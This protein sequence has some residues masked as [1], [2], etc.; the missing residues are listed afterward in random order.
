MRSWVA[1]SQT[2]LIL[3]SMLLTI[4]VLTSVVLLATTVLR[5]QDT[6]FDLRGAWQVDSYVLADGSNHQ[7]DGLM[8]FSETD[9]VVVYFVKDDDGQPRRG[10]GEGG[11]YTLDG[12]R[13]VLRRDYLTIASEAIRTLPKIPLR[14][15]IPGVADQ[16]VEDCGLEVG[17]GRITIQF[18]SGNRMGFRRRSGR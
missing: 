4:L 3:P 16:V 15:D 2:T 11:P 9:W 7:V 1:P 14:F 8:L 18:P 10:A 6:D 5:A 13:L 12:D 17:D